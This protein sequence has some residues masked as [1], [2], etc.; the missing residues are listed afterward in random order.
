MMREKIVNLNFLTL[1]FT[2]IIILINATE[3]PIVN[4]TNGP[5]HGLVKQYHNEDVLQ[6]KRIPYAEP[7]IGK[8]RFKKPLRYKKREK[9]LNAT[10]LGPSCIQNFFGNDALFLESLNISEDCL[11]LNIYVPRGINKTAPKAVMVWIHGGGFTAGQ[12]TLIDGSYLAL[13]GDVIVVTINYRLGLLGFLSTEDANAPGNYGIW[14][15]KLAIEWVHDNAAKFGGDQNR[16]TIFGESAGGYSVGLQ[17]II[18]SNRGYFHRVISQSG[19]VYSPR[20]LAS[21]SRRVANEAGNLLNCSTNTTGQL[22]ECLRKKPATEILR[23]QDNAINGWDQTETFLSRLGPVIDG[24]L[25]VGDPIDLLKNTKLESYKFFQSLDIM[26][27]TNNAEGGLMYWRMMKYQSPY[28]FNISEGIPKEALCEVIAPA[29]HESYFSSYDKSDEISGAICD[30]YTVSSNSLAEQGR[31]A[32]NVYADLQFIIPTIKTLSSHAANNKLNRSTYQ[33]IFTHQPSYP[34]IQSRPP[35]LHGANHA[36][37]LPFVFGLE[38]MY[39]DTHE[40]PSAEM[41]LSK[42]IMT[43]WS[44]FAKSGNPNIG[45]TEEDTEHEQKWPYFDDVDMAFMNLT[46]QLHTGSK[47]FEDRV[48]FWTETVP[49]ML[50]NDVVNTS[51]KDT[52]AAQRMNCSVF[53]IFL[54]YYF[55]EVFL[56]FSISDTFA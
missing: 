55:E 41:G 39:P 19:T 24:D 50:R 52:N 47:L 25:I 9:V 12:G 45:S 27:G 37:E 8:L 44:N 5:V 34:W 33:Y 56:K 2:S 13:Q 15:Q 4:T 1:Y 21:D 14:D 26:A 53:L 42:Q 3:S 48:K 38:A 51:P 46:E 18:S 31:S 17:T 32:V 20:A 7:P 22:V 54:V 36:G 6:F 40:K 43:Y 23:V 30:Q 35:W 10:E 11:H 29:V 49:E 16:I 28:S